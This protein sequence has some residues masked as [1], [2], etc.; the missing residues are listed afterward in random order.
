MRCFFLCLVLLTLS[1][2]KPSLVIG[3][4]LYRH[5][6]VVSRELGTAFYKTRTALYFARGREFFAFRPE[7]SDFRF[8]NVTIWGSFPVR[9]YGNTCYFSA[10]DVN[11][12]LRPLF[13]TAGSARRHRVRRIIL[14]PG[15]G[16]FDRGAAG[17]RII[18]KQFALKIAHRTAE[19]LRR[20]GYQVI[21]TRRSDF[22]LPLQQRGQIANRYQGDLFVSLHCNSSTD[23]RA[24]GIETYCLTPAG[25]SS[26]NQ[27]KVVRL[28]Y[29]GNR[30]NANNFLLAF[31]L[32][33]SM[34]A[35]TKGRDRG[36]RRG[37]FAVLRQLN[38]PGVLLEMGFLSNPAEEQKMAAPFHQEQIARAIA[39]GIINYHRRIYRIK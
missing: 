14:D 33:K 19:I 25:A 15:H 1:G 29:P 21:L 30:F 39:V 16:G 10:I 26:T 37:R 9:R 36:V 22:A 7:K 4:R 12:V 38:M 2:A 3:G 18:E 35:R 27:K 20:C 11:S 6:G 17:Q 28:S 24:S 32:Q 31:E 23:R 5:S 34:L 8:S 13:L